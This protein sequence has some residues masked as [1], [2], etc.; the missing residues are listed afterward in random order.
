MDDLTR[1]LPPGAFE[2]GQSAD[3]MPTIYVRREQLVETMRTLRDTPSLRYAFLADIVGVDYLPREPRFEVVYLLASLGSPGVAGLGGWTYRGNQW[4]GAAAFR[5]DIDLGRQS[6]FDLILHE[7]G[8]VLGLKH[9]GNYDAAGGGS[10]GPFLP[11][12]EDNDKFTVMS[13]YTRPGASAK[14]RAP[15]REVAPAAKSTS[16]SWTTQATVSPETSARAWVSV[17]SSSSRTS[18]GRAASP[19][20]QRIV[21]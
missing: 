17:P 14:R 5:S 7:L 3:G 13:Y 12:A 15:T 20:I 4:D 8:H 9:P 2:P 6:N 19:A 11:A 18:S 1:H 16:K 21:D 10:A